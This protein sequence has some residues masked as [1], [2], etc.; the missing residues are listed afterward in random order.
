[1]AGF[2]TSLFSVSFALL[3]TQPPTFFSFYQK[4]ALSSPAFVSLYV[5]RLL[6]GCS[7]LR[8]HR[9]QE[10]GNRSWAFFGRYGMCIGD[11]RGGIDWIHCIAIGV[12]LSCFNHKSSL[13]W[14]PWGKHLMGSVSYFG[15]VEDWRKLLC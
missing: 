7:C 12:S 8:S 15:L 11:A 4:T 2:S 6:N 5:L 9:A 3:S 10:G 14:G 1:M 13:H